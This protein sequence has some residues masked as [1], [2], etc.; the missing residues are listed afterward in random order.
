MAEVVV[1]KFGGSS[2]ADANQFAKVKAIVTAAPEKRR[3]V[4]PSAPG[5][6]YGDDH[7]VTDLLLMCYQLSDHNID[8]TEVFQMI[9]ERYHAIADQLEL[10]LD[11]DAKLNEVADAIAAGASRHWVASRGEHLNGLILAEYLGYE[12]VDPATLI[13]F[14]EA[15]EYDSATT[16]RQIA[17]HLKHRENAIIPGFYGADP[18]G[19]VITFSRGGSD[20]TGAIIAAGLD[21]DL[22][23]NWTD[24]SGFLKADP[25]IVDQPRPIEVVTYKEL[26]ELSYMGAS[27]LH[28]DAIFP[29]R[30]KGIPIRIL[31]TNRAED[32][33]TLIVD[34]RAEV[35]FRGITGIAGKKD[36]TVIS[37]EKTLMDDENGF[38]RRLVSV[39]ETNNVSIAHM[40]SGIDT[41]SVIVA[42]EDIRFK[43]NKVVEEIKIYCQPDT[44]SI[45]SGISLIAVVGRGMVR[46]AGIAGRVF[47]ALAKARVNVRMITQGAS[48]MSIIV[49]VSND[50]FGAAVR[51]VY[52]DA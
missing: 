26:R 43:L 2:L 20:I 32:P 3:F 34:D 39:F 38:F 15:E 5:K 44:V 29:V 31:N 23:E 22:Y 21:A 27:V 51:A 24:V 45:E 17:E 6:R 7:K 47:T 14:T 52:E 42:S 37:L 35:E 18:N 1:A 13:A 11:L 49:G 12:F 46:T 8:F 25:R 50:D 9:S 4:V 16:M 40:P 19:K 33:G 48:E 41:V 10:G 28:E 36:F 30:E